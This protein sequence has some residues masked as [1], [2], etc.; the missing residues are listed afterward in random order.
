VKPRWKTHVIDW[1]LPLFE[2]PPGTILKALASF[3]KFGDLPTTGNADFTNPPPGWDL[4]FIDP[5][6]GDAHEFT[7]VL[8]VRESGEPIMSVVRWDC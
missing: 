8:L 2:V 1:K 4:R 6:S 3:A 5:V 7:I